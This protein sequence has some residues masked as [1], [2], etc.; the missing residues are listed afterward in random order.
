[1]NNRVALTMADFYKI[2]HISQY[3]EN[4]NLVFS[5]I[6]AR[7]SR[8][9]GQDYVVLF[10]VQSFIKKI[11][12]GTFNN[13]FFNLSKEDAVRRYSRRIKTSLGVIKTSH[14]EG[15]HDLGYLPICIMA[16][17]EGSKVPIGV[18]MLVIYNTKP[19][20]FWV[21]NFVETLMASY[22]WP[23]I[24]SATTA[25]R[26]RKILSAYAE[27]TVGPRDQSP[28]REFDL[29]DWQ[30]HDFSFRGMMGME[31]AEMSGAAHL[32]SFYGTDTIPAID[33]LEEYYNADAEKELIGGSVPATEHS[34][35]C[36]G[37]KESE[38]ETYRRLISK[39]YPEGIV[40]IVSDTWD[41]W[42][43]CSEYTKELKDLIMSRNG[44]VVLRPD[45][46]DPVKIIAGDPEAEFNS[47]AYKGAVEVL[48]DIFGGTTTPMGYKLLDSHIGLIYGDSITTERAEAICQRLADKGF[49][50]FNCVFG[51]GSYTYQYVSRDTY[52]QAIKATY[53]EINHEPQEI[54]KDPITDSGIKKSAKGLLAVYEEKDLYILKQQA[55]WEDISNCAFQKVFEN[56]VLRK[57]TSLAEIRSKLMK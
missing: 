6:T 40:S 27:K 29:L 20:F 57:E 18:P 19:E 12:I 47:P 24:N 55:S 51:I 49:A 48:W 35:M 33:F 46:G 45:S 44:K 25:N 41:F 34:V 52:G 43:V 50:S 21:T 5:N 30:G 16:L 23:T 36:M 3:P 31:A 2:D 13:Y 14:I 17:P 28:R 10:G 22:T 42:K 53:G 54:F 4:T 7:S 8:I 32:L 39:I 56:G 15:L 37:S 9:P 1:M 38:I 26:Y 11:L